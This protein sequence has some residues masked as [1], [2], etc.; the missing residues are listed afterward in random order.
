MWLFPLATLAHNLEEAIWLPAWSQHGS[1]LHPPVEPFPFALSVMTL[2]LLA[3]VITYLASRG[4]RRAL[5]LYA[6]YSA[7]MLANVVVPHVIQSVL[8]RAY[9]PGIATALAINLPLNTYLLWA[10]VLRDKRVSPKRLAR[11]MLYFVPPLVISLP[12]LTW[13]GG[14]L[15]RL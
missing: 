2:S 4:S 6:A 8:E 13:L 7:A 11:T 14:V 3:F 10:L 9:T 1:H 5:E 15:V 12:M